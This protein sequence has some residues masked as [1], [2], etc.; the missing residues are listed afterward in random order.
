MADNK[1][2][3]LKRPQQRR[4]KERLNYSEMVK[5]ISKRTGFRED[6]ISQVWKE[7]IEII[8]EAAEQKKGIVLPKIGMF[9]PFIKTGRTV[10]AMNGGV[11]KPQ[12][13]FMPSKWIL[14]FR[15]SKAASNRLSKLTPTDDEIDNLYVD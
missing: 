3:K 8:L 2:R 13:Q 9:Y 5:M 14:K 6:D 11:G 1:K 12:K 7:G 15:P 10:V 4:P